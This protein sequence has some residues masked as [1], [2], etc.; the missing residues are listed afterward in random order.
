MLK[1]TVGVLLVKS[2]PVRV[3]IFLLALTNTKP[4]DC[5]RGFN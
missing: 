3:A 1:L 4:S 5:T 2:H